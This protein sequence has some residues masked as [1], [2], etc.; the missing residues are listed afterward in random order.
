MNEETE[1]SA[2]KA[3]SS[4]G[5]LNNIKVKTKI[6]MGFALILVVLAIVSGLGYFRFVSTGSEIASYTDNVE[7]AALSN[8]I[9]ATFLKL[10][11]FAREFAAS[12]KDKDAREVKRIGEE[13]TALLA[14]A[15]KFFT[16]P[17][18]KQKI[19][20]IEQAAKIYLDNFKKAEQLE[21]SLK[22]QIKEVL[23]PTG[24]KFMAGLD[25]LR[26]LAVREGN[27]D[28][29][30]YV[31]AA[32]RNALQA[33]LYANITLGRSDNSFA[34][35]T[36]TEF[37]QLAAAVG[38]IGKASR[39]TGERKQ[40]EELKK[41]LQAYE[42]SFEKSEENERKIQE[43]V[44]GEMTKAAQEITDDTEWVQQQAAQSEEKIRVETAA[45]IVSAEQTMLITSIIG[46]VIGIFLG[47]FIGNGI[48]RPVVAMTDSMSVLAEGNLEAEIPAQGRGDEIGEM[49]A[50]VQVFKDNAIRVKQ[51][52]EEAR[53]QEK[54]AAEEK[55]RVMNQ[56]ADDFQAS[57]GGVVQTVS[58]ASTELQSS[59]QSMTAISEE[60]SSQATA[61]AAASEEA[62]TNVQTVA[63]AAEELSSSV[64]EINR[65]VAQSTTIAG[66]AVTAAEKA[67]EM[68]QGLAMSAQKISEVVE[69]ITDIAEQTNLLAL[70]A[71]I[72]AARAGEA[73]KGFAVV[74]S[75][76]KNLATQTAKATEEIGAQIGGI[77]GA[78]ED[79]VNAIQ[80]ITRTIGEISEISS[81]IAAAVE[82]QSAA[83]QEIARNVE[84]AAAGTGEVSSNIQGVTQAAAEAGSTSAQVLSAANELS[85][86]SEL[87]KSEVDKF[88]EQVRKT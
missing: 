35:R 36:M 76:V 31:E 39:T 20:A 10:R 19:A 29:R 22:K 66:N 23:E 51:M 7:D 4:G 12:G 14:R 17:D 83:T 68:V 56:M 58:A 5:L 53:E 49:A 57:V 84:Q 65:Q 6:M 73:G 64:G 87:L 86:Q 46:I 78:T 13:L 62:S 42:Q 81:A 11:M 47:W 85:E 52:E 55:T 50:A 33:R 26:K 60:T 2:A 63:A 80:D 8:E 48:S 74:A 75:E 59:A 37:G 67:N 24:D 1:F 40:A 82:E 27:S 9:E 21:G 70:N 32:I 38:A 18:R 54:R 44:E 16:E 25:N 41:L 43:L 30:N 88:M 79:S 28:A 69:M 77:Q 61:V 15:N 71:T 3:S 34:A 45:G 72:E